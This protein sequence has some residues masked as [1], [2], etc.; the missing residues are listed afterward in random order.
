MDT[1]KC[2]VFLAA[3]DTGSISGAA[4]KLGYTPSG[5]SR[6]IS[7]LE[8]ETGFP[9]LERG[10][11]GVIPTEDAKSLM[12]IM[13]ELVSQERLYRDRASGI[14]KME[15]GSVTIGINYAAHFRQIS[16]LLKRFEREFPKVELRTMQGLSSELC[17][18]LE[19][20]RADFV[21]ASKREGF[22]FIKLG[23]DPM[24]A[25]IPP[26]HPCCLE[27]R[28]CYPIEAFAK[29]PMIATY[30][31]VETDYK[32]ALKEH[33]ISPNI[34]YSSMNVYATY[35]MV[36]AGLGVFMSNRL[37]LEMYQG[38]A[39]LLPLDPPVIQEIGIMHRGTESLS[40]AAKKLLDMVV[41]E[42]R[43]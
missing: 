21:I 17:Q 24:V 29:D 14:M 7:A 41:K 27:K 35:C 43:S 34:R 8:A 40:I 32:R 36:E 23:E 11:F 3:I 39:V 31:N 6:S 30:P 13:R 2:R 28:P 12:P 15:Q 42:L 4:S 9:L 33:G 19:D 18:A 26:D 37:E 10:R 16:G 22:D 25:C 1:E 5:V 20:H 38:D